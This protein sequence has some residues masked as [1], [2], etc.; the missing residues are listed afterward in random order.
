[1]LGVE[2]A[3]TYRPSPEEI[4]KDGKCP[5]L[6]YHLVERKEE[7]HVRSWHCFKIE[8]PQEKHIILVI[9]PWLQPWIPLGR[10]SFCFVA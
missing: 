6:I 2:K 7:H 9:D 1:M 3:L 4:P 5:D 10:L 8:V